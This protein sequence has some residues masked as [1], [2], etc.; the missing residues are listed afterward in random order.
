MPL[1][2]PPASSRDD[3]LRLSPLSGWLDSSPPRR[4]SRPRSPRRRDPDGIQRRILRL[5]LVRVVLISLVLGTTVV[6]ATL[7][8][9]ELTSRNTLALL[10]IVALTFF[11][12]I[13]YA[14]LL[15]RGTSPYPLAYVQ[16]T[17]DLIITTALV[18]L[19]G[20]AQ[21][22]YAFFYPLSI[23]AAAIIRDRRGAFVTTT[24][25]VLLYITVS[26][27][28]W[29]GFLTPLE[30]QHLLPSDMTPLLFTRAL[31]INT[32]AFA[33]VGV[34]AVHLADMLQRTRDSLESH[35]SAN[36]DLLT[37]HG[38]IVR[39]LSSGLITTDTRGRTLTINE[40][41]CDIL[42][43]TAERASTAHIEDLMP[44]LG[45]LSR[46]IGPTDSLR[47]G[48]LN[49]TRPGDR[50]LVLGISISPLFNH[51]DQLLGRVI[52]FQDLSELRAMER[53]Y[54]Q[55]ERLAAV[56]SLAAGIAHEIRNPLASISG[57]IELLRCTPAESEEGRALMGIVTREI[58][59][60]N[61]L[62]RDLLDYTNPRPPELLELDLGELVSETTRVFQQDRELGDT[63][64]ALVIERDPAGTVPRVIGDPEKLRQVLWNL[65]RNAAQ[66][67]QEGGGHIELRLRHGGDV[68]ELSV[69]DDGPGIPPEHLERI[70]DPFFTTKRGGTGLGLA[71]VHS[72]VNDHRGVIDVRSQPGSGAVFTVLLPAPHTR[73]IKPSTLLRG[74]P[75]SAPPVR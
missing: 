12:T 42:G 4:P 17:A 48:E 67:A 10:G 8:D 43:V 7:G 13:V 68:I 62:I 32:S 49:L 24:L 18:H 64:V 69:A 75:S 38:D 56:G 46:D 6:T 33:A 35:R 25:S 30:G 1:Q 22:A 41:A 27:A 61:N 19:S 57:S 55:A 71:T 20:G 59:R 74:A 39:C 47:R 60:L 9:G 45:A 44:G 21:S 40:V 70:F 34:L 31:A 11:L 15:R 72:I 73:E 53:H 5:M 58:D 50:D 16:L 26:A 29:V 37:L 63:Q 51:R 14:V 2:S 23:I 52:N 36:A 66:A 54:K 65:L 28:G 3:L